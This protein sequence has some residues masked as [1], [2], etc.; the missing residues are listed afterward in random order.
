MDKPDINLCKYDIE[1]SY[2]L[3][4][5]RVGRF[6]CRADWSWDTHPARGIG[7][8]SWNTNLW[9]VLQGMGHLTVGSTKYDLCSGSCFI[10]RGDQ[11]VSARHDPSDPLV[12]LAVHFDFLDGLGQPVFPGDLPFHQPIQNLDFFVHLL[13]RLE[14][15]WQ[16]H[17]HPEVWLRACLRE[18]DRQERNQQTHGYPRKQA[19]LIR[20]IC[21]EI[22]ARP[23][24]PWSMVDLARRMGCSR[25]H[26]ARL[27]RQ[28]CGCTPRAYV[29]TARIEAA[30]GLLHASN[31]SIGQI[32]ELLG[33]A[34]IYYFSRQFKEQTGISPTLYRSR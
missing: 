18:F 13:E 31:Y 25:A 5:N 17:R 28:F 2:T 6:Y 10:L 12:V 24:Q 34:D 30:K 26:F 11:I 29:S 4:V 9:T 20:K 21:Q 3:S 27:F 16:E 7:E 22:Q 1:S 8:F 15:S 14:E 33:Y 19:E 23:E 32:S